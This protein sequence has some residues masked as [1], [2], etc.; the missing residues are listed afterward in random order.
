M[1]CS[2]IIQIVYLC[3]LICYIYLCYKLNKILLCI[4]LR[5]ICIPIEYPQ[6]RS[7]TTIPPY[8]R[9]TFIYIYPENIAYSL[10]TIRFYRQ[11]QK[12]DVQAVVR[13][14]STVKGKRSAWSF[15]RFFSGLMII[16]F[17]K[18]IALRIFDDCFTNIRRLLYEYSSDS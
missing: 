2:C 11:C 16:M 12:M 18:M 4:H 10:S 6:D 5:Y 3:I 7:V 15:G 17:L 1:Y 14:I 8:R 13:T 9:H